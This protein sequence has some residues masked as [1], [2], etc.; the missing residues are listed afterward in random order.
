MSLHKLAN[1]YHPNSVA[2]P[3]VRNLFI[4]CSSTHEWNETFPSLDGFHSVT[5]LSLD[6][7]PWDEILPEIRSTISNRFVTITCIELHKVVTT[8][9]SDLAEIIC[10]F[11]CLE[12]LLLGSTVWRTSNKASS[13]L[14]LPQCLHALELDDSKFTQILKWLRSFGRDLT[15]RNVSFRT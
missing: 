9:F 8:A 12:S 7:L 13:S 10:T 3:L 1:L 14:R 6:T 4:R 11:R 15:L 2:A 5:L